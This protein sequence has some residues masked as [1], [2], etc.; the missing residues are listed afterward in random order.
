VSTEVVPAVSPELVKLEGVIAS[1][2]AT[3]VDVGRAL[4]DVRDLRLYHE[5]GFDTFEAYTRKHWDMTARRA[6]QLVKGAE[7]AEA[8]G[9]IVPV[10]SEGVARELAPL[11][12]SEGAE[13]V[14][15]AWSRVLAQEQEPTAKTVRSVLVAEGY[16][17]DT[18]ASV[19]KTSNRTELHGR[20][21]DKIAAARKELE[22][23]V[24]DELG[25]TPL[26][27]HGRELAERYLGWL[28]AMADVEADLAAGRQP[29]IGDELR[30]QLDAGHRPLS[31]S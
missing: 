12:D 8:A 21:G 7:V 18:R 11:L 27:Q 3:F 1:G 24:N 5:R 17:H 19:T 13:I 9:T 26:G 31:L 4:G 25:D 10:R 29:A 30:A 23:F 20:V 15:E 14:A 22:R 16:L 6:N 2:L 28:R